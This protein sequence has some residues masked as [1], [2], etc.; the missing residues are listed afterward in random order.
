MEEV[1][2]KL[3]F[4]LCHLINVAALTNPRILIF[5]DAHYMDKDSWN[6]L[7][8]V[9]LCLFVFPSCLGFFTSFFLFFFFSLLLSFFRFLI[10]ENACI[11]DKG[12]WNL[13]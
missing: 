9:Y 10:F 3:Q 5:E 12:S 13:F 2:E 11:T 8:E 4:L 1:K 7:S 6:L